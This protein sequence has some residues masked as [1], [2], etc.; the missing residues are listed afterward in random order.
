MRY[1]YAVAKEIVLSATYETL[2]FHS[3][4]ESF[5]A[6]EVQKRLEGIFG[7]GYIIRLLSS[8]AADGLITIDQYDESSP[9][10]YT[11]S[12]EG[13]QYVEGM[14]PLVELLDILGAEQAIEVPAAD[15][16]VTL[17]HNQQSELEAATT[18]VVVAV[19]RENSIDGDPSIRQRILGQLKAGR[20]LISA[21]VLNAHLLH[22]T[23]MS[24][25]GGLIE[26]YKGHAIGET[27]KQLW[28]LLL[29]HIFT[30]Q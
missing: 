29:K 9:R 25:L 11:L 26:K 30:S 4:Y 15:R 7:T 14:A 24:L 2:V 19:E 22:Q 1:S 5:S 6:D 21:G 10:Q 12:D 17:E 18:K 13:I 27:A 23:L 8:L 3:D 16:V 20:E 28:A